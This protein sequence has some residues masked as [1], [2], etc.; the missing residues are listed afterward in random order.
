S[1]APCEMIIAICDCMVY[2]QT[3]LNEHGPA[4][5]CFSFAESGQIEIVASPEIIS[6]VRDTL[7]QPKLRRRF[8]KLT[9]ERV[10][11]FLKRTGEF[12]RLVPD[13]PANFTLARDPDDAKYVDLAAIVQATRIVTR[14]KDLLSLMEDDAFVK[15][16][17]AISIVDPPTFLRAVRESLGEN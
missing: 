4:A 8:S 6:E 14:D 2:V 17:P 12:V 13:A 11:A 15:R 5:A 9:D 3:V 1:G 7:S 10:A 16:F